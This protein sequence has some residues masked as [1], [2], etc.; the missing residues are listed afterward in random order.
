M[1]E[2]SLIFIYFIFYNVSL[3]LIVTIL[4]KSKN[5][6][7]LNKSTSLSFLII[8][9]LPVKLLTFYLVKFLLRIKIKI[10]LDVLI[11]KLN[12]VKLA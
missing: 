9:I 4:I 1:L 7:N 3:G 6:A 5:L 8:I 11:K 12:L 10:T 2:D